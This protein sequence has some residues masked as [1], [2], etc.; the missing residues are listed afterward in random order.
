M[1]VIPNGVD[2][3]HFANAQAASLSQ[4]G[5]PQGSRVIVSVGRLDPQKGLVYLLQALPKTIANHKDAHLLLVGEG[6]QLV[7]LQKLAQELQIEDRVHF[8]GWRPDVAEILKASDVL[9]LS[10]LW[11]GMP[12][13][14]LEAMATGIPVVATRV[15]GVD[16]LISSGENGFLVTS[17]SAESLFMG[18]EEVFR[19]SKH[20]SEIVNSAQ[21]HISKHF[22]WEA[23]VTKY[24]KLY[25]QI[26]L[27]KPKL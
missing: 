15:E 19:D 25:E 3:E 13:V 1:V 23:I 8:A 5:I 11:E 9:V 6:S 24:E 2:Y 14:V 20:V 21:Q 12:N 7:A 17:E 4:F 18:I 10:S 16:E 27:I 26:L 22:T